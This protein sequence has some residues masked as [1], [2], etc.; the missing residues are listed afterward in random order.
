[1]CEFHSADHDLAHAMFSLR[2]LT[3]PNQF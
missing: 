3:W 2:T 1:M